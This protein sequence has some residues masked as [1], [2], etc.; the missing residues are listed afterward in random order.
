MKKIIF[1]IMLVISSASEAVPKE[2]NSSQEK[3]RTVEKLKGWGAK[4]FAI[5]GV[6]IAVTDFFKLAPLSCLMATNCRQI[7][8]NQ[9]LQM[10]NKFADVAPMEIS[11]ETRPI[12]QMPIKLMSSA[13]SFAACLGLIFASYKIAVWGNKVLEELGDDDE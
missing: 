1:T 5:A 3:N 11:H 12:R 10:D 2:K 4:A 6:C 7:R 9:G 8:I 13:T